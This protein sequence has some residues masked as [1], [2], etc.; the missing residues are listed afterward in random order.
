MIL[1]MEDSHPIFRKGDARPGPGI[2][3]RK[4]KPE[5]RVTKDSRQD[6]R[7]MREADAAL[8]RRSSTIGLLQRH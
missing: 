7:F 3:S 6:I 8:K 2:F 5:W 1:N 4:V